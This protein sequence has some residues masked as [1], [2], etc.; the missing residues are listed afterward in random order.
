MAFINLRRK[1]GIYLGEEMRE[2]VA[3]LFFS[4]LSHDPLS[5]FFSFPLFSFNSLFL[6]V[7]LL[8][9]V[10]RCETKRGEVA[11]DRLVSPR[12]KTLAHP[13]MSLLAKSF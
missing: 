5:L 1:K 12:D 2:G 11:V 4:L 13:P 6:S 7:S 10:V 8:T 3:S 9:Y